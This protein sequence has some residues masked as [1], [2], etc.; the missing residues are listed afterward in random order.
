MKKN[1]TLNDRQEDLALVAEV[2]PIYK[3][4]GSKPAVNRIVELFVAE[5]HAFLGDKD[6]AFE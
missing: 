5:E 4:S 6:H 1:A 2:Q 3:Q